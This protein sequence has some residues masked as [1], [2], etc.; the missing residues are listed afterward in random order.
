MAFTVF[1][2][3]LFTFPKKNETLESWHNWLLSNWRRL[4]KLQR[5]WNLVL[6]LQIVQKIPKGYWPCLY[7]SVGKVWW[8]MSCGS[9]DI[10]KNAPCTYTHHGITNLVNHGMVKNTKDRTSWERN[11]TFLKNKKILNLCLT[12]HILRS[13]CFVAEVTFKYAQNCIKWNQTFRI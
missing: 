12:W 6:V 5:T 11:T 10:F 8:L 1:K 7:L 9:K 13:Y 2:S 3:T 4:L